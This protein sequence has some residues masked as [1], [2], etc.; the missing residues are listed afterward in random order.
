MKA[1]FGGWLRDYRDMFCGC[2]AA[3]TEWAYVARR[4]GYLFDGREGIL[5]VQNVLRNRMKRRK[6]TPGKRYRGSAVKV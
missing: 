3:S 5:Y 2:G 4:T 6:K 1:Y